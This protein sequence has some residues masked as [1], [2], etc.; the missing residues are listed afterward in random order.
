MTVTLNEAQIHLPEL[1]ARLTPGEDIVIT[2]DD[3]AV[4]RL[5]AERQTPVTRKPRAR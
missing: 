2:Q 3:K 1:I 4:A 5:V